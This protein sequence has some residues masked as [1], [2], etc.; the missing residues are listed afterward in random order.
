M[1]PPSIRWR[2]TWLFGLV[3]FATIG[4]ICLGL[5]FELRR[6]LANRQAEELEAKVELIRHLA[7]EVRTPQ[8]WA[9]VRSIVDDIVIGHGALRVWMADAAGDAVYGGRRM[10]AVVSA[11]GSSLRVLRED[12][13]PMRALA[14]DLVVTAEMPGARLVAALDERSGQRTLDEFRFALIA[15]TLA[16]SLVA[17]GLGYMVTRRG[18]AP[19]RTLAAEASRIDPARLSRRLDVTS[20][21]VELRDLALAFNGVL[22]R[23][24]QSH[25][26][27]EAFNSDVAHELRTPLANL[28]AGTEL[29]LS[30]ER[31]AETYREALA[32][33]LE[34]L[35]RLRA[36]VN[37]MLF[38][39][40]ADQGA[41]AARQTRVELADEADKV[42]AYHEA[43]MEE[44]GI[45]AEV[46]GAAAID[47][48][49]GL[50]RRAL[51]NLVGNA[52]RYTPRGRT[53]TIEIDD[54]G[55]DVELTVANPG[56]DLDPAVLPRLFTRFYRADTARRT[57]EHHYGLG[58]AIVK[59]IAV[60]HEG[61]VF[62][63]CSGGMTRIGLRLPRTGARGRG[64]IT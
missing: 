50:L 53:F 39:A 21:P 43:A 30:R 15:G 18:L 62:A 17:A 9:N 10:P 40:R 7:G 20:L 59:A 6:E 51:S 57:D 2:L 16:S 64:R 29:A 46:R 63:R 60:M 11:P 24:H 42:I 32:S 61:D 44:A 54:A 1:K 5:W 3:A 31:D 4:A 41:H 55:G 34:E 48:D 23:L 26:H 38:L 49:A 27:L 52:I 8:D 28:M 47:A 33:N 25:A 56:G 12:G 13:V 45:R 58:L 14:S 22:D 37:D 36:M 19:V 35:D